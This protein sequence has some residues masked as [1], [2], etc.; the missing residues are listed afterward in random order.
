MD[1][2]LTSL[3]AGQKLEKTSAVKEHD[4]RWY[5]PPSGTLLNCS[6][7]RVLV[8]VYGH[9]VIQVQRRHCAGC[10]PT[11]R[12]AVF[13][14]SAFTVHCCFAEANERLEAHRSFWKHSGA[15]APLRLAEGAS[16]VSGRRKLAS[17]HSQTHSHLLG[18]DAA[19]SRAQRTSHPLWGRSR[20]TWHAAR[21]CGC[22]HGYSVLWSIVV[23]RDG[24][25]SLPW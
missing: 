20:P 19:T 4:L 14:L 10:S 5:G 25:S 15:C 24:T 2:P 9:P 1:T 13:F 16:G 6:S 11:T 18:H 21:V 23:S 17:V 12:P 3:T 22:G 7:R 8:F